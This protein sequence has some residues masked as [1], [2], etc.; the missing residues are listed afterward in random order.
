MT[1][2]TAMMSTKPASPTREH[3]VATVLMRHVAGD[4]G[5]GEDVDQVEEQLEGRRPMVLAG[6]ANAPQDPAASLCLVLLN[7]GQHSSHGPL[8]A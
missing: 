5:D 1:I 8:R 2:R 3:A 7:H 4:L 6:G